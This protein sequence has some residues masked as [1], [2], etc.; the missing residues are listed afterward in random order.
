MG[1]DKFLD[2]SWVHLVF[3]GRRPLPKYPTW[4]SHF[5]GTGQLSDTK[6][7]FDPS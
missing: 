3:Q 6:E 7:W 1:S 2:Q 5:S 4:F